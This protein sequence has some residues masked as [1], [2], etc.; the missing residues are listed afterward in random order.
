[1]YCEPSTIG[2]PRGPLRQAVKRILSRYLLTRENDS[3]L[4]STRPAK[5]TKKRK[6]PH[7][8]T[9]PGNNTRDAGRTSGQNSPAITNPPTAHHGPLRLDPA[10]LPVDRVARW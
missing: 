5:G 1:M 3:F 4:K 10:L 6:K 7:E 2:F 8:L 9:N